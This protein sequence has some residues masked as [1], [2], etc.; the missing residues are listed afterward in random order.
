MLRSFLGPLA[1][2][3]LATCAPV[4]GVPARAPHPS[5]GPSAPAPLATDEPEVRPRPDLPRA[6]GVQC[7]VA[8]EDADVILARVGTVTLT[9]CDLAVAAV[10]ATR[11][12]RPPLP[13]R[14]LLDEL[15]ADALLADEAR[16]RGL[17][18]DPVTRER[19]RE[20]LAA[21]LVRHETLATMRHTLP[22]DEAVAR[23]YEQRAS[24][25]TTGERVHLRAIVLDDLTRARETIRDAASVPFETLV[26]ERSVAPEARR[27]HGDLGLVPREG[28]DRVPPA[29]AE[30][31][32]ALEAPGTVH[33]EPIRIETTEYIGR[34]R[35]PHTR[36]RWYV[37][38]LLSRRPES[39]LPLVQAAPTIRFRLAWRAYDTARQ[40]MRARLLSEARETQRVELS[41]AALR[42]VRVRVEPL[43][44]PPPRARRPRR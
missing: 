32:F 40:T 43:P 31:G 10:R 6:E 14:V 2:L 29:V 1:L 9:A 12:G 25:F 24:E 35:R 34:R 41:D 4:T 21:A 42:R 28:T 22:S 5:A 30:A 23:Y 37:I 33:P 17:D 19:V 11:E 16:N 7:P 44:P 15:V 38:Q 39:V 8:F 20:T 13:P 27:D 26:A 36:V 18:G 3:T